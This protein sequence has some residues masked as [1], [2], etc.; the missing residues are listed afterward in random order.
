MLPT[1][2]FNPFEE[3]APPQTFPKAA[4]QIGSCVAAHL[5]ISGE[6]SKSD[7]AK[8]ILLVAHDTLEPGTK[9]HFDE[10]MRRSDQW[11]FVRV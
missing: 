8:K 6:M 2:E 11:G 9:R 10:E 3:K 1:H 4:L 7:M 5:G